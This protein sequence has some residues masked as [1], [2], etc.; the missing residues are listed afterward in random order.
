MAC[1]NCNTPNCG[2]SGTYVVSQTCPPACSEVFNASCIVYTGVDLTC[3]NDVTGISSTVI[4]RND[5]LDTA[6]TKIINFFCARV[7]EALTAQSIVVSGDSFVV[8]TPSTVGAVTTYTVTLD[9]AGLPTASI[10]TAGDNVVVT[11]DGSAGDPYVVN[12]HES[13][14]DVTPGTALSVSTSSTG[15]YENTY[16]IDIDSSL[17][18][19]TELQTSFGHISIT[20]IPNTPN[21]GDTT[22]TLEVDEV[23]ITSVD[24]K[25]DVVNTNAGGI[26]P[27]ERTF[28]VDV[29]ETEMGNYIMDTAA[30]ILAQGGIIADPGSGITVGYDALTHTITIGESIGVPFQWQTISDGVTDIIAASANDKLRIVSDAVVDGISVS[31]ASGPGANEGTFTIVNEDRGSAQLTFVDVTCSNVSGTPGGTASAGVNGDTLTLVG[32]TDI[33]LTVLGNQITIDNLID[34]VY[35]EIQSDAGDTLQAP[36]TTSTFTIAGGTGIG[37]IG[38]LGSQTI[39]INNDG[40]LS[41]TSSSADIVVDNTNPQNPIINTTLNVRRA[42][43]ITGIGYIA[44]DP[45]TGI[46]HNLGEQFIVARAFNGNEDVTRDTSFIMLSTTEV[47]ITSTQNVD[48]LVILY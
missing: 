22:Y 18:P 21:A 23:T 29:N 41:V 27:F 31:L 45:L 1:S 6:L 12:S 14:V 48:R 4:S 19:V 13:I 26:A 16:T 47:Q 24:T 44:G 33:D 37:T 30:G 10:V 8:V 42:T 32:G 35:A 39:T 7:N 46:S 20:E 43:D 3:T 15:P 34:R 38:D 40:V 28:T 5:Y 17:L 9:P 36:N 25:I 2:C 11:G